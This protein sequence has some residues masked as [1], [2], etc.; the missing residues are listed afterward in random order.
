M[1]VPTTACQWLWVNRTRSVVPWTCRQ[2]TSAASAEVPGQTTRRPHATLSAKNVHLYPRFRIPCCA[3][4]MRD[5]PGKERMSETGRRQWADNHIRARRVSPCDWRTDFAGQRAAGDS[6]SCLRRILLQDS[7]L[8]H[9]PRRPEGGREGGGSDV[10][11]S[12]CRP[13][14]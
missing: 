8:A 13:Q 4:R 6:L 3:L 10:A 1:Y 12:L 9:S 2:L 11:G 14:G 5:P 7:R